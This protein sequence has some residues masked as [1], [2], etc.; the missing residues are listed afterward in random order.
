MVNVTSAVTLNVADVCSVWIDLS[1]GLVCYL[2][3]QPLNLAAQVRDDAGVL[4]DVI[5]HIQQVSLYLQKKS[6][7]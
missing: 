4:G 5:G 1:T 7:T 2:L 3:L 6:I